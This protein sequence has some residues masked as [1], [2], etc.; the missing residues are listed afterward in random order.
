MPSHGREELEQ[1]GRLIRKHTRASLMS[2]TNWRKLL[3][4][5]DTPELQLQQCIVKF[6]GIADGKVMRRPVGLFPPRPWIDTAEFGPIPLRSTQWMLFPRIAEHERGNRSVP[7]GQVEQDVDAAARIVDALGK[8]PAQ[9]S[10][11]GLLIVGHLVKLP[12]G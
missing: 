2:D 5:F 7:S 11:R 8:Y 1:E 10:E 9:L 6:V 12:L 3:S 4:A